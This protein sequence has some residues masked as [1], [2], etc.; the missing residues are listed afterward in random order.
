MGST[1]EARSRSTEEVDTR[2][3]RCAFRC[4]SRETV[5]GVLDGMKL[6]ARRVSAAYQDPYLSLPAT[7]QAGADFAALLDSVEFQVSLGGGWGALTNPIR[8]NFVPDFPD[9]SLRLLFGNSR[10]HKFGFVRI[11]FENSWVCGRGHYYKCAPHQPWCAHQNRRKVAFFAPA[12][13]DITA[14]ASRF[15]GRNS[16]IVTAHMYFC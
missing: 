6:R 12:T 14:P 11:L 10:I 5:R 15:W 4:G 7:V 2:V 1:E 16:D 13:L 8:N 3:C 9:S